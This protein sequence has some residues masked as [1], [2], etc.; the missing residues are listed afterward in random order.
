VHRLADERLAEHDVGIDPGKR[1]PASE[2]SPRIS[3]TTEST[4]YVQ[5]QPS[6][7]PAVVAIA[8]AMNGP[9]SSPTGCDSQ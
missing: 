7:P 9:S 8:P 5:R 4:M 6:S 1:S 3:G 2:M